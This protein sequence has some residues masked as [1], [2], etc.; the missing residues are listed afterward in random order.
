METTFSLEQIKKTF[1]E[2]A[3]E[4]YEASLE[5]SRYKLRQL[6]C[7]IVILEGQKLEYEQEQDKIIEKSFQEWGKK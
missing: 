5:R 3:D 7:F 1:V 2:W 4:V 6:G